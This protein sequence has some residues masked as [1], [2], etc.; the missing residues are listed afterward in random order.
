MVTLE[1]IEYSNV[2]KVI[3]LT[4]T[5]EQENYVAKNTESLIEAY[6]NLK[7]GKPALPFAI[8]RDDE[9]VGF[10]MFGYG[11]TGEDFLPKIAHDN[12]CLWRFMVD[13]RYQ[14]QGIGRQAVQCAFE[15]LR[16]GPLG[17]ATHCWLSYEPDN[18]SGKAFY[19]SLGFEENGENCDDEIVMVASL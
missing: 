12:Y 16:T 17:K 3:Q 1:P 15:Y 18:Q 8:K 4:V 11:H 5:E 7:D 14:H 10:M 2:W 9:V 6:L 13:Q 19:Q